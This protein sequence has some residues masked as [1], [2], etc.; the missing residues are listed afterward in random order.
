[1]RKS[2]ITL[3]KSHLSKTKHPLFR[4]IRAIQMDLRGTKVKMKLPT[5]I[6]TIA[7]ELST[8]SS[9]TRRPVKSSWT[10]YRKRDFSRKTTCRK[11]EST[12]S[13]SRFYRIFLRIDGLGRWIALRG[14]MVSNEWHNLGQGWTK[15]PVI[16]RL[17]DCPLFRQRTRQSVVM[18]WV[19]CLGAKVGTERSSHGSISFTNRLLETKP[20]FTWDR[21][22]K[23]I[24]KK[25]TK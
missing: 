12:L 6:C 15:A 2:S 9:K 20:S 11:W 22:R 18:L 13:L 23:V 17:R 5:W 16:R 24:S 14:P 19:A 7:L 1:M 21:F 8:R 10:N 25:K 3:K 4:P